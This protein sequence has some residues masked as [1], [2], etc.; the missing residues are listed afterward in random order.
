MRSKKRLAIPQLAYELYLKY[1]QQ[2]AVANGRASAQYA[3]FLIFLF[4]FVHTVVL[5]PVR[6]F[7]KKKKKVL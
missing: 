2:L 3:S 6:G 1:R 5:V 4:K 7:N